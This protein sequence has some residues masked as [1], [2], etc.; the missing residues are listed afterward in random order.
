MNLSH[1]SRRSTASILLIM[2]LLVSPGLEVLAAE[3]SHD[4]APQNEVLV[5]WE[6]E[7]QHAAPEVSVFEPKTTADAKK[8]I[9]QLA[10]R[11]DIQ[12]V[13]QNHL[14]QIP[15]PPKSIKA[16]SV[17]PN[18][19]GSMEQWALSRLQAQE[20]WSLAANAKRTVKV[21]VIDTGI[22][23]DHPDLA[24]RIIDGYDYVE[25]DTVPDD[26][27]G[28]G[29]HVSGIIAALTD[30]SLGVSG[31][32]GKA[33]VRI[34][35][36]KILDGEGNGT[37]SNEVKAIYDAVDMG[38]SVI[39]LSLGA[40]LS[41][42]AEHDAIRYAAE[43]GV[44]VVAAAGN[45]AGDVDYPAAYPESI[46]VAATTEQDEVPFFSNNGPE[47]DL[48]APG[49]DIIS[50]IPDNKYAYMSGTSMAAPHVS[51]LAALLL[52]ASP[53]PLEASDLRA[54]LTSTAAD[55][56]ARGT[57]RYSG[58]GRIDFLEAIK[59]VASAPQSA[60]AFTLEELIH[61]PEQYVAFFTQN[62]SD[63]I[64]VTDAKGSSY[65]WKTLLARTS[66]LAGILK[67]DPARVAFSTKTRSAVHPASD[68]FIRSTAPAWGKTD[69]S[70]YPSVEVQLDASPIAAT[71]Q[72]YVKLIDSHGQEVPGTTLTK[73]SSNRFTLDADSPLAANERYR[74]ML[75]N[76][77]PLASFSTTDHSPAYEDNLHSYPMQRNVSRS[78]TFAIG[79]SQAIDAKTVNDQ[80][81]W[82][83]T[84]RQEKIAAT[85][86]LNRSNR[87]IRIRPVAPMKPGEMYFLLVTDQIRSQKGMALGKPTIMPFRVRY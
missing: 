86:T 61:D 12:S 48:A 70:L 10:D 56:D 34:I 22:D 44:L 52:A 67:Q 28:H 19:P 80:S 17:R 1:R 13:E 74:V 78:K 26:E 6:Q 16:K 31:L 25:H 63:K 4:A 53:K 29:T 84:D 42:K 14:V 72:K 35:P 18:D 73:W 11:P 68:G 55:I 7:Y 57:D 54:I 71:L 21:A 40:S 50:T 24:G 77:I 62:A 49:V 58:H 9:E 43:K 79:F 2:S 75:M 30:N 66:T 37:V 45:E 36:L 59:Q 8:L 87:E 83:E 76:A 27:N 81:I 33:D 38:A 51:A 47:I 82:I 41:S 65:S 20:A 60:A 5:V 15:D 69:V 23:P 85:L 3:S 46:A 39:N 32:T 64:M